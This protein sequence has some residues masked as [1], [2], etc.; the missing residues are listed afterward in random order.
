MGR[1]K[2]KG[3]VCPGGIQWDGRG[4]RRGEGKQQAGDGVTWGF[5]SPSVTP[6]LGQGSEG[7][8][9]MQGGGEGTQMHGGLGG[10]V[11]IR[12]L[13]LHLDGGCG[14]SLGYCAFSMAVPDMENLSQLPEQTHPVRIGCG[15]CPA[16][17]TLALMEFLRCEE[18]A[19][20]RC[21]E[22]HGQTPGTQLNAM[23]RT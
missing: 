5:D 10:W 9:H 4:D 11:C 2:K 20:R 17:L 14:G 12:V 15:W 18:D 19:K 22:G 13:H 23:E 6:F 16:S 8:G 21:E 3:I 7:T 1:P